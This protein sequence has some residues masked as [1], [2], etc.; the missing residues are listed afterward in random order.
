MSRK[1]FI[2]GMLLIFLA[3]LTIAL[4]KTPLGFTPITL[5]GFILALASYIIHIYAYLD[6]SSEIKEEKLE[7]VAA[8]YGIL[9]IL[10]ILIMPVANE[11][12]STSW[13]FLSFLSSSRRVIWCYV[14]PDI[15][16]LILILIASLTSEPIVR[17]LIMGLSAV[18]AVELTSL[19]ALAFTIYRLIKISKRS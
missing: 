13:R 6:F 2:L 7:I 14:I 15:S 9:L 16:S 11:A 5:G 1:P 18:I 3:P 10:G 19:I 8:L 4:A 12:L 17:S